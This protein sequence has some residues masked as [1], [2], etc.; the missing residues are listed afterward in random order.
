MGLALQNEWREFVLHIR[1]SNCN[2]ESTQLV[3]VPAEEGAPED[4]DEL[5]HSAA[6]QNT[7]YVCVHCDSA[8]GQ[9]IGVSERG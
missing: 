9:L 4:I 2:R 1:C 8:I 3:S 5:I 6:L 7:P